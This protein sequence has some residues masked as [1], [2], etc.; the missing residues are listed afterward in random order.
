LQRNEEKIP[1]TEIKKLYWL[2]PLIG[3]ILSLIGLVIP[4]WYS[5]PAWI[6]NVWI[7]GI[8]HHVTG[9]NVLD[10]QPPEMFIPSF[11]AAVLIY[12]CSVMIILNALFKFRSKTF[13]GSTERI[14]TILAIIEVSA[15]IFYIIG[16]QIGFYIQTSI[17]FGEIYEVRFGVIAPFIS[18]S[19]T[20]VGAFIGKKSDSDKSKQ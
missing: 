11:I 6:E 5:P 12:L 20:L 14:W 15:A 17:Y 8:I 2:I 9:G 1:L 18:A 13:L 19:L 3:G 4:V 10:T 7:T 16:I